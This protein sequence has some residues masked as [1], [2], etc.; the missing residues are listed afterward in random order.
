M[1]LLSIIASV[2][3]LLQWFASFIEG[4]K[5]KQAGRDEI[6]AQVN[7]E[8]ADAEK[9]MAE[10][11][12]NPSDDAIA[13]RMSNGT[14]LHSQNIVPDDQAIRSGDTRQGAVRIPTFGKWFRD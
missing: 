11:A 4:E 6:S 2:L 13:D 1:N 3:K 9:R 7:K 12:D 8:A 5:N 14:F 10:V